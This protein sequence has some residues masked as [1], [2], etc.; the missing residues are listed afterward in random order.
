MKAI[1]MTAR[2]SADEVLAQSD[3]PEPRLAHGHEILVRIQA[4]GVNPVDA[5][6]RVR[7]PYKSGE[8]PVILGCDA[9]GVVE[10]AGTD[11]ERFAPGDAVYFCSGGIGDAPGTYAEYT[12][13]D[14]RYCAR[15]PDSLSFVEAAAAPLV[16]LTAWESLFERART[17][18]GHR[19]LIHAGAGGVG[20]VA[21]QLAR[22]GGARVATTVGSPEKAA[23]ATELGAE[24]PILYKT[25]D[26]AAAARDWTGGTGVDVALDVLGG[27][28]FT[29]TFAAMRPYGELI[30][31]L[32]P[33][34][35]TDWAEARL[36]NLRIGLELMLS[37]MYYGMHGER[38]RQAAILERCGALFDAGRLR[39]VVS[40][41]FPLAEAARAHR[42]IETGST[43]GKLVLV[44]ND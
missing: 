24:A 13:V 30:T 22:E 2:G 5:K 15:K 4:A 17:A 40:D 38:M 23:L 1:L 37:P 33:P 10:E 6:Q 43:T 16:L 44:F 7:G 19:V 25:T 27:E 14:E 26:F 29:R 32:Q 11:C 3:V 18:S 31:V 35:D 41:T 42:A 8:M 36:R 34:P 21:I 12:V 20:H 9:A 39:V 28:T